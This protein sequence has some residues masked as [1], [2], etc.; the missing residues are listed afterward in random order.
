MKS[1]HLSILPDN[2]TEDSSAHS[3]SPG[4]ANI[5]ESGASYRAR[6]QEF[7]NQQSQRNPRR[8]RPSA[9]IGFVQGIINFAIFVALF[10]AILTL[11]GFGLS[12][13]SGNVKGVNGSVS[14]TG[15]HAPTMTEAAPS[16][17]I[18]KSSGKSSSKR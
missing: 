11:F 18:K 7:L 17:A 3:P 15:K 8:A 4:A 2:S 13:L 1:R 5:T 6:Y 10:L 16:P 12:Q 14:A 9:G